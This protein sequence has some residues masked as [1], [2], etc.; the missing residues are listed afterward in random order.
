MLVRR[1]VRLRIGRLVGLLSR[2]SLRI[3]HRLLRVS[4]ELS[5]GDVVSCVC[6]CVSS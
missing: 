5:T 6:V 1:P 4:V 2:R 3:R